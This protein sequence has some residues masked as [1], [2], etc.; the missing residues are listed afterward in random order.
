MPWPKGL[1]EDPPGTAI[2]AAVDKSGKEAAVIN[3]YFILKKNGGT[4]KNSQ[5]VILCF[6]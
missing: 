2:L 5:S 3:L 1:W 6:I 4:G